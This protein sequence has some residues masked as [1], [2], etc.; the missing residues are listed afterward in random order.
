M[1]KNS[2]PAVED[3]VTINS[4]QTLIAGRGHIQMPTLVLKVYALRQTSA[5]LR[6]GQR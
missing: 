5:V 6:L 3:E 2:L 1:K 4:Q